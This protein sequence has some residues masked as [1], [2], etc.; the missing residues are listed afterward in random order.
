MK[1]MFAGAFQYGMYEEACARVLERLGVSVER[2]SWSP[3]FS[4]L[5]G[6]AQSKYVFYGPAIYRLNRDLLARALE[7]RPEVLLIWRGTHI[8][9]RTLRAI[10][11]RTG[12]FLVSY[13]NDDPFGPQVHG[14][15]PFHHHRLWKY[16]LKTVPDYDLH[17]VYR[18]LN[19]PEIKAAG[20]REALVLL[21]YFVPEIHHPV[22]LTEEEK[23]KYCCE[24]VFVGHYEPDGRIEYLRALITA[25]I[26]VKLFGSQTW[27]TETLGSLLPYF[28]Q[29][30][31]AIGLEYAKALCGAQMCLCFLSRLNRDTYTRRCFEIPACGGLL[32]SERTADLQELFREDEEAI[33]FSSPEELVEKVLWL[34]EHP[35]RGREMA[36]AGHRRALADHHSVDDR[37]RQMVDLVGQH[38]TGRNQKR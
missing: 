26:H 31:P 19:V 15:V 16:Y 3:Y 4:G 1:I 27:N 28:G 11:A 12:A 9:P 6:R 23:A 35:E 20:A 21:P 24:A 8:L 10:R 33:Y 14:K 36:Q 30:Q 38:L 25:G 29:V 13:N 2:F 18:E 34:R 5:W 37:M 32:V 7:F 22:T 17:F